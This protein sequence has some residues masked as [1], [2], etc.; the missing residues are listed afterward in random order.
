MVERRHGN[1]FTDIENTALGDVV[2]GWFGSRAA[3]PGAIEAGDDAWAFATL[4][5]HFVSLLDKDPAKRT[6]AH[7]K[8]RDLLLARAQEA[9]DAVDAILGAENEEDKRMNK[10]TDAFVNQVAQKIG[11]TDKKTPDHDGKS[12]KK[13]FGK[14][15]R[16]VVRMASGAS[17]EDEEEEEEEA[18]EEE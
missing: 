7:L 9:Q 18:E 17:G 1:E 2:P 16:E 3:I 12:D 13:G 5:E 11:K 14:K 6:P 10:E 15:A 8:I 4:A